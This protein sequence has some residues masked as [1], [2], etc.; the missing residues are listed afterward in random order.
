MQ[1]TTPNDNVVTYEAFG[2]SG[3]GVSDDLPAICAAHD[4]ANTHGLSVRA[5]PDATYHLGRRALTAVIATDV[6]W[7]TARFTIDDTA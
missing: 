2:A 5:R 3:D 7:N 4:Y 6:D 1:H